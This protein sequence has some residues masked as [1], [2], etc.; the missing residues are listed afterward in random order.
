MSCTAFC[1]GQFRAGDFVKKVGALRARLGVRRHR[2]A[3]T[4]GKSPYRQTQSMDILRKPFMSQPM[5]T[6]SFPQEGNDRSPSPGTSSN[7]KDTPPDRKLS[8][9]KERSAIGV[10]GT[11][12]KTSTNPTDYSMP[13]FSWEREGCHSA[14]LRQYTGQ[15]SRVEI[16][17]TDNRLGFSGNGGTIDWTGLQS[18]SVSKTL[19]NYA[20]VHSV[21]T[22]TLFDTLG[23]SRTPSAHDTLRLSASTSGDSAKM[24]T[25]SS[26]PLSSSPRPDK[27]TGTVTLNADHIRKV[28][29]PSTS[30]NTK[31]P[32]PP[33]LASLPPLKTVHLVETAD[34]RLRLSP[35]VI[36]RPPPF[37]VLNL[38][39]IPPPTPVSDTPRTPRPRL[40]T[41]P[42]LPMQG[43]DDPED[44]PDHDNSDL[45]DEDDDDGD[46]YED[47]AEERGRISGFAS[48][49]EGGLN[50]NR[51][52]GAGALGHARVPSHSSSEDT[53]HDTHSTPSNSIASILALLDNPQLGSVTTTSNIIHT[54]CADPDT[55]AASSASGS[56]LS[57]AGYNNDRSIETE[58][59]DVAT[60]TART[61]GYFAISPSKTHVQSQSGLASPTTTPIVRTEMG[62]FLSTSITQVRKQMSEAGPSTI[63]AG[64]DAGYDQRLSASVS[65]S[66]A[67]GARPSTL[68]VN[69]S[70]RPGLYHQASKS[71]VDLFSIRRKEVDHREINEGD[72]RGLRVLG[73]GVVDVKGKG[74]EPEFLSLSG[75]EDETHTADVDDKYPG[76]TNSVGEDAKFTRGHGQGLSP[77]DTTS[78]VSLAPAPTL[79]RRSSMPTF[80][81]S[82][83]PPPYPS[84]LPDHLRRFV[85][86]PRDDEGRE[87]LPPYTNDIK[88]NAILPRKMEFSSPG[89]HA[90][91]RKWRRVQCVLEGTVFRVYRC[92]SKVA[93]V[94]V[95]G[96]WWEKKVGVGDIALMGGAGSGSGGVGVHTRPVTSRRPPMKWEQESD[97]QDGVSPVDVE[98]SPVEPPSEVGHAGTRSQSRSP[99]PQIQVQAQ[100]QNQIQSPISTQRSKRH[101]AAVFLHPNRSRV[102]MECS[103]RSQSRAGS[104]RTATPSPAPSPVGTPRSS[105]Q[106][107]RPSTESS[108]YAP[109]STYVGASV[110][111]HRSSP[112][113]S[114]SQSRTRTHLHTHSRSSSGN[115]NSMTALPE[116]NPK[117]LLREYTLQNAESG[118]ASD[119]FKRKNVIRVRMEGEQFLLQAVDIAGVVE[120]IEVSVSLHAVLFFYGLSLDTVTTCPCVIGLGVFTD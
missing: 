12:S 69:D 64:T 73:G 112:S 32:Q 116:P 43:R 10:K 119:Y 78:S 33:R 21:S 115:T 41:V 108:T 74:K 111:S 89:V 28:Q 75:G 26:P 85:P 7:G 38:P 98:I 102:S 36:V 23:S 67:A 77:K 103:S 86:T 15:P 50:S 72:N 114:Q 63:F 9:T 61:E 34:H 120:W 20:L 82:G 83:P 54:N 42:L 4:D 100:T 65:A 105:L 91:D 5:L 76:D 1:I 29:A 52:P 3:V 93:G 39:A 59:E 106:M 118:L 2:E 96:G 66:A 48:E 109:S 110:Q 94:G 62:S 30:S 19:S 95:L 90:K 6:L 22:P 56:A 71:M 27:A 97:Q 55:A 70:S 101:L 58:F 99:T 80:T 79:R 88:I 11:V 16:T 24:G 60:P 17:N 44:D 25:V 53:S 45:M 107:P 104:S 51:K 81:T 117:D 68:Y 37:P 87:Q 47:M 18:V 8:M 35:S 57:G 14:D 84:F 113:P 46:E 40:N 92:P 49:D 13:L 31:R